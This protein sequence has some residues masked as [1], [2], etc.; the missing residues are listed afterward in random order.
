MSDRKTALVVSAHSAD[1]SGVQAEQL[2]YMRPMGG[3]YTWF[4]YLSANVENP[5]SC[6]ASLE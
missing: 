1:L 4:A 5:Q 6:G 2:L 3:R